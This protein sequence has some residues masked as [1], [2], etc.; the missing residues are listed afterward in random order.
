MNYIPKPLH[1]IYP[2]S[3][4]VAGAWCFT[5][6]DWFVSAIGVMLWLLAWLVIGWLLY[7]GVIDQRVRYWDSIREVIESSNKSD[8]EKLAAL[9]F[10]SH[11][12]EKKISIELSDRRD[13][14]NTTKYF[15]LPISSVKLSPIA[16]AVLSG[17]PFT[18]RRWCGE[19]G[20]LS[21]DEFR[22]LRGAMR[23]RGFVALANDKDHRQGYVL[24]DD[25][26]RLF[27]ELSSN[28]MAV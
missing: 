8:L 4:F 23:E 28:S 26:R 2:I 24:T 12:I 21:S 15:D 14:M 25:G 6:S 16:K 18:E 27:E 1:L 11:D 10:T 13:G 5:W 17:Q 20:L 19:A 9:G 3:L 7:A 22:K